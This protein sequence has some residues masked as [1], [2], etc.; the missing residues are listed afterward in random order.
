M[1]QLPQWA[2]QEGA[3]HGRLDLTREGGDGLTRSGRRGDAVLR[4]MRLHGAWNG[5]Q[6]E[7]QQSRAAT[8]PRSHTSTVSVSLVSCSCAAAAVV[9][10]ERERGSGLSGK[11]AGGRR[12]MGE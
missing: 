4:Y 11:V 9:T 2:L 7:E 10:T 6:R 8:Q 12:D 3:L 5:E 1:A